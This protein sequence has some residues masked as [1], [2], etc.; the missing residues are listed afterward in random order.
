MMKHFGTHLQLVVNNSTSLTTL[1]EQLAV[2]SVAHPCSHPSLSDT[3]P[4]FRPSLSLFCWQFGFSPASG[5]AAYFAALLLISMLPY[6][7]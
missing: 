2:F 3:F 6:G 1:P 4:F 5:M 7:N